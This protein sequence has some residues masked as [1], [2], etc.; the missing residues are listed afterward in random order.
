ML[1][2]LPAVPAKD[3]NIGNRVTSPAAM[4]NARQ[5]LYHAIHKRLAPDKS[6]FGVR[7]RLK[8]EVFATAKPD[9]EPQPS[10]LARIR[11][12]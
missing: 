7:P 4:I 3:P 8:Q 1:Q 11:E 9:L 6:Y 2:E 10:R 12:Q 5:Q